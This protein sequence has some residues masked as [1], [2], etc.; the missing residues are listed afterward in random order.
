MGYLATCMG[1]GGQGACQH[2]ERTQ[3]KAALSPIL[4]GCWVRPLLFL[5]GHLPHSLLSVT[6]QPL[7]SSP[8]CPLI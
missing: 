7:H 8:L 4:S 6:L 5:V 2:A 3:L 1:G